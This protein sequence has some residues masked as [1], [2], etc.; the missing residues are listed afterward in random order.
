MARYR[1]VTVPSGKAHSEWRSTKEAAIED[2]ID[3]ELAD[4]DEDEPWRV[5]WDPVTA[6]EYEDDDGRSGLLSQDSISEL[7]SAPH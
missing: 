2:A 7:R 6:V 1:I 5:Y 4:L 3:L